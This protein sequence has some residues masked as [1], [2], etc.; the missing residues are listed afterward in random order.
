MQKID[1]EK[2]L[3]NIVGT[4]IGIIGDFCLDVYWNIDKDKSE[5]SVETKLPT[6]PVKSQMYSLGG[7]GNVA[8]NLKAMGVKNVL[9]FGVTGNDP[10]G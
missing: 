5:S 2:V 6:K 1:L 8:N 9:A 10:F 3:K 4:R 7:A